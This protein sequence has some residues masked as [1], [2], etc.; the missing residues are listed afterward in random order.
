MEHSD[1]TKY[2]LAESIKTIM[3]TTSLDKITVKEIVDECNIT[4]Q[5]F[6]RNFKDKYDLVNWYF[7]QLVKESFLEMGVSKTLN[8]ALERKFTF[9]KK[10]KIFFSQAF[11]S[12]DFNNLIDYDYRYIL[13][14]YTDMIVKKSGRPLE[15]DIEFLLEFYC[16]GSIQ[17]TVDWLYEG[18]K[19][20]EKEISDLL[21]EALPDKLKK[22]LFD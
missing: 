7:E 2:K 19:L 6:Y 20:S 15:K 4:R 3:K 1:K 18:M 16:H 12:R 10:E 5:T 9:I 14:F 8:E 17:M 21:C 22:I 11:R 13:N